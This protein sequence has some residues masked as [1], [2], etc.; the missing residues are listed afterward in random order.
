M[1]RTWSNL[2]ASHLRKFQRRRRRRSR[3]LKF[4]SGVIFHSFATQEGKV[5]AKFSVHVRKGK[6][7]FERS[8]FGLWWENFSL[9]LFFRSLQVLRARSI[10][11]P[12][13]LQLGFHSHRPF[14][15]LL[16]QWAWK[17]VYNLAAVRGSCFALVCRNL[18]LISGQIPRFILSRAKALRSFDFSCKGLNL[19]FGILPKQGLP[20]PL[21]RTEGVSQVNWEE[22]VFQTTLN[23]WS[24]LFKRCK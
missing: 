19:S 7:V 4:W 14:L 15:A 11:L 24:R 9:W 8:L 22:S 2:V 10:N 21:C 13:V 5:N 17:L 23:T 16:F 6:S 3:I 1:D 20:D 12:R 18:R